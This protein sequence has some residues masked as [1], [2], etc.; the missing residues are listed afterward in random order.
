MIRKAFIQEQGS[1]RLIPEMK[2]LNEELAR[3]G[4]PVSLFTEKRIVRRQLPLDGDSL[5]AGQ[6][7]AV[8]AAMQQL[9]IPEPE[10]DDYPSCL[11]DCLHRRLWTATLGAV[12]ERFLE[13]RGEP[14][15]IKPASRRKRFTGLV[16]E[17][18]SDFWHCQGTSRRERVWCSEV[19][20]WRSECRAYV[21]RDE[22]IA[23]DFYRGDES[24]QLDEG[25]VKDAIARLKHSG[26]A[27]AAFAIDFGVLSSGETALIERNDGFSIGAY[28]IGAGL[29]TDFT[30][31]RWEELLAS[32]NGG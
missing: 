23:L 18:P 1:G 3:R 9:G 28:R 11:A 19:V 17:S 22:I 29:Y 26:T 4:I 14:V 27:W 7:P 20:R 21:L 16:V 25:V 30:I 8:L 31:A 32:R 5:V 10:P 6:M 15:F 13:G 24:V 2:L 12:E